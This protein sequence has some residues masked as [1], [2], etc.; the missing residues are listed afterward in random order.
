[1]TG[2][3]VSTLIEQRHADVRLTVALAARDLILESRSTAVTVEAIAQRAAVSERT[4]YRH[5]SSKA[6]LITPLFER[7]TRQMTHALDGLEPGTAPIVDALVSVFTE[8]LA[9]APEFA[10]LFELLVETSEYRLRWE[11][12]DPCLVDAL[13]DWLERWSVHPDDHF[14]RRVTALLIM[15]SSRASHLEWIRAG[16]PDGVEGLRTLHFASIR[17]VSEGWLPR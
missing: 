4:F 2:A 5:F 16:R 7:S 11:R 14:T 13:T 3:R 8:E 10:E 9:A 17:A 6:D 1:M 12:I 15:T